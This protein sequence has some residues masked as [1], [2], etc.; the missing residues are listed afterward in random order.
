MLRHSQKRIFVTMV[1]L[2]FNYTVTLSKSKETILQPNVI[3]K[4]KY[5]LI[6]W[7]TKILKPCITLYVFSYSGDLTEF[8]GL[9]DKVTIYSTVITYHFFYT[10][11]SSR[12]FI[13]TTLMDSRVHRGEKRHFI[14]V[15]YVIIFLYIYIYI[16]IYIYLF[17]RHNRFVLI[18]DC[19]T[20]HTHSQKITF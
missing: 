3:G 11:M 13:N 9:R 17:S 18:C 15:E 8:I 7:F 4:L 12:K 19:R 1:T 10:G 14:T 20:Y 16:Y 2:I 6:D 5:V